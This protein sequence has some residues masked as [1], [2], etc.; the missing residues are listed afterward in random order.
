V[1]LIDEMGEA[2]T[3]RDMHEFAERH[4]WISR[5][6]DCFLWFVVLP[7]ALFGVWTLWKLLT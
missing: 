5:L 2:S 4:P 7:A 1:K 6:T 3:R